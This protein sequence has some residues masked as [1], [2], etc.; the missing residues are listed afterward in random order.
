MEE[1]ECREERIKN[2]DCFQT[3]K[4]AKEVSRDDQAPLFI[5]EAYYR[6]KQVTIDLKNYLGKWV[7]LFFYSSN[8]TFV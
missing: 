5:A 2:D 6:G 1:K 8:F 4:C 3:V 7:M